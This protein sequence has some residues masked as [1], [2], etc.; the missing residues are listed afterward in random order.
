MVMI[1]SIVVV[2]TMLALCTY[3][4]AVSKNQMHSNE[5]TIEMSNI[6]ATTNAV[7]DSIEHYLHNTIS[8]MQPENP[9]PGVEWFDGNAFITMYGSSIKNLAEMVAVCDY[10]MMQVSYIN[11]VPMYIHETGTYYFD[12]IVLSIQ[13]VNGE[14]HNIAFYVKDSVDA[15]NDDAVREKGDYLLTWIT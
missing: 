10:N 14:T 4:V 3:L 9:D 8:R 5:N 13:F 2:L 11:N 15:I 12:C 6:D 7:A 1:I